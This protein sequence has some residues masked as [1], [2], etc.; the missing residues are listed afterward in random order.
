[1]LVKHF[2][3]HGCI[4]CLLKSGLWQSSPHIFP[5]DKKQANLWQS[6]WLQW[7]PENEEAEAFI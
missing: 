1:M 3:L 6:C 5:P 7:N 4:H 2:D